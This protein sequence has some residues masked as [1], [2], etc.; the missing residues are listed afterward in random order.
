MAEQRSR[1]CQAA[2]EQLWHE[3]EMLLQENRELEAS[4]E[5]ERESKEALQAE[6]ERLQKE[7]E[8]L[9]ECFE[10]SML[11]VQAQEA[12]IE[13]L[14]AL[15]HEIADSRNRLGMELREC[16]M[17]LQVQKEA[18]AAAAA[19]SQ[20]T[21]RVA[22]GTG[23]GEGLVGQLEDAMDEVG[24]LVLH[25]SMA[26][27]DAAREKKQG[28]EWLLELEN[29][30]NK[31]QG[32]REQVSALEEG[33]VRAREDRLRAQWE[34]RSAGS[35]VAG[36]AQQVVA[37]LV[38]MGAEMEESVLQM[39]R[40]THARET[41]VRCE[42]EAHVRELLREKKAREDAQKMK[43]HGRG[44][45][46]GERKADTE[47]QRIEAKAEHLREW[48]G[49]WDM[50]ERETV[51]GWKEQGQSLNEALESARERLLEEKQFSDQLGKKVCVSM[52][53]AEHAI[54]TM[55]TCTHTRAYCLDSR[56]DAAE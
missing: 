38:G 6:I 29:E 24:A 8:E 17:Q 30:R 20:L 15:E 44:K 55:Q 21:E 27:E 13:C 42:T 36:A 2:N 40:E 4:R 52:N 31:A 11:A 16:R 51:G 53:A 32:L 35:V 12:K 34:G 23:M 7:K 46:E 26:V 48:A 19:A 37:E 1:E 5:Q 18:A 49:E 47:R 10:G 22:L 43:A 54:K 3:K 28:L 39:K 41:Q 9:V 14:T 33:I 25:F 45:A 50:L 56:G